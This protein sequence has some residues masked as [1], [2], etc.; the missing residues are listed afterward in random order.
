MSQ[1]AQVTVLRRGLVLAALAGTLLGAPAR[2]QQTPPAPLPM[3][4]VDFPPFQERT[5]SNGAR[6]LVVTQEEVPYVTVRAVVQGGT[7]VDPVDR[8]GQTAFL[9]QLL[10]KGTTTRP[11]AQIAEE[12]DFM[13]G[14][15]DASA[16][17]DWINVTLGVLEPDLT[18]GLGLLADV[19]MHPTFPED[20]L[21]LVRT[22][23][24][25][26]LEASLAEPDQ[27]AIR[28]FI[29]AVYGEHPYGKLES[30]ATLGAIDRAS[31]ERHHATWF[32][33]G[34]TLFVV[35]GSVTAD[36]IAPALESAFRGWEGGATPAV[37]YGTPPPQRAEVVLVDRPGS[38]QAVVLAGHLLAR[39]SNPDWTTLS[40]GNHLLGGGIT[41]R[42]FQILREQKG[43]T[44]GAYSQAVR[45]RDLGVWLASVEARTDVAVDAIAE[46]LAQ[47]GRLRSELI[48]PDELE[49]TK[50]Y[51]VG[52]FPLSI[53]TPQ[54]IANQ[55]ASNRLLGLPN[56]ALATYRA[57]VAALDP[58]DVRRVATDH[59]IPD[60][61]V[62]VVV[63]DAAQLREGLAR[64]GPVRVVG[65]DGAP[66]EGPTTR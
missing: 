41:S 42:L 22:R 29:R 60:R 59:L 8:V 7:S 12:I 16:G 17:A 18:A 36:E 1:R 44:Y 66:V 11:A 54:Q 9:A 47:V 15:L 58:S 31:L 50:S 40:V 19:M 27:L 34:N 13:G 23:A 62:L 53:E 43:W 20:E 25:S 57:R 45:R 28:A 65:P 64:F 37:D 52:S 10:T 38:V 56:D 6:L 46:L 33:P 5:L 2:A 51:L 14:S 39:G 32:Q 3:G 61:M 55:V 63:G 35:A 26:G 24:L 21:E 49:V 48:P 4:Q 30:E